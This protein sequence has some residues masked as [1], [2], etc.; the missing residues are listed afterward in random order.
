MTLSATAAWPSSWM[1]TSGHDARINVPVIP[2]ARWG[3]RAILDGYHKKFRPF[4]RHDVTTVV[5]EPVDLSA[6]REQPLTSQVLRDVTD[7]LMAKVTAMVAEVRG[8]TPPTEVFRPPAKGTA[9]PESR[10]AEPDAAVALAAVHPVL[11]ERLVDARPA[12]AAEREPQEEVPVLVH[13]QRLVGFHKQRLGGWRSRGQVPAH[14]NKL[15]ALAG[16][17]KS[18]LLRIKH[19][20]RRAPRM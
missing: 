2:V 9:K 17:N 14:A 5:G 11:A 3:T 20:F 4:P 10:A 13:L 16:K 12:H 8:E 18:G 19:R 15:R 6:Y 7:L 1:K